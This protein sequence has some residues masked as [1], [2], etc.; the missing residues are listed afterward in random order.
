MAEEMTGKSKGT[1]R[2]DGERSMLRW[3]SAVDAGPKGPV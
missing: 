2:F 1:K 3:I